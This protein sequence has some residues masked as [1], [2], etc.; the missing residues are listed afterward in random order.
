VPGT[1]NKIS[2]VGSDS[3]TYDAAGNITDDGA[4]EY[5]W[6]DAGQLTFCV[7]TAFADTPRKPG[8]PSD[9]GIHFLKTIKNPPKLRRDA[10]LCNVY[11][12]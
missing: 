10:G 12:V 1:S 11:R 7:C 6:N 3:Y 5:T 8:K 2:A 9:T 4:N